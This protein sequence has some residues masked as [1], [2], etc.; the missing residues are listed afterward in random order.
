L[1]NLGPPGDF[2]WFPCVPKAVSANV[3]D[4]L[5]LVWFGDPTEWDVWRIDQVTLVLS[6]DITSDNCSAEVGISDV[7]G[8][9]FSPIMAVAASATISISITEYINKV[10]DKTETPFY[11]DQYS[12]LAVRGESNGTSSTTFTAA[13]FW[14][15]ARWP[16]S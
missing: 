7:A 8:E 13:V 4:P 3:N 10:A 9:A 14:S 15:G 1:D 11:M 12:T 6:Y 2:H 5:Y 16:D